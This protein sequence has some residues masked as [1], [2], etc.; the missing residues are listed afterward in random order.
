MLQID[1]GPERAKLGFM[2]SVLANFSFL[3]DLGFRPVQ[4]EV[5]FVRYESPTV[6]VNIYHGRSSFELGVEVGGLGEPL[7]AIS[8]YDI[9]SWAGALDA[10]GFGQHVMFQVSSEEGV[11]QFVPRLASLVQR[12]GMPFLQGNYTA[13]TEVLE[14]RSHAAADYE[15]QVQLLDLRRRAESAWEAKNFAEVVE[16][17]GSMKPNMT[18]V[19]V[20]RLDYAEKQVLKAVG[21]VLP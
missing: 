19:E 5:T 1:P 11:Q 15:K 13:Y 4:E 10:E 14:A 3:L 8:L 7:E 18:T 17:Y 6:F 16:L 2:Q 9:I 21:D 12:Y 20:K